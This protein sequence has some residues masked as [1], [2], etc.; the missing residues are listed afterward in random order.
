FYLMIA[1]RAE[2]RQRGW[3]EQE[4]HSSLVTRHS[5]PGGNEPNLAELLPLVALGTVADVVPLDSN[6]RILVHQGVQRI[7]AGRM[8]PGVAAL[9]QAAGRDNR[10]ASAYDL[11][12]VT[13]PRL[14]AAGRLTDM[15]LGIECRVTGDATRALE[16]AADL[17]RLNRQRRAI[18]SD[19]Q[20]S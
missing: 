12:F 4:R 19:M 11:G 3:F 20:E 14:N 10:R 13:G 5:S 16:I 7:R 18:E 17:D 8:Q 1:L 6:N 9:F 15:S 2:L